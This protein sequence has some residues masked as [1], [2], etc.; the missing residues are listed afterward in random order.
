[1]TINIL[2]LLTNMRI[3]IQNSSVIRNTIQLLPQQQDTTKQTQ[4][5]ANKQI[6]W[7]L[8]ISSIAQTGKDFSMVKSF[9]KL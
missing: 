4:R 7:K 1:M 3:K 5:A 8:N 9:F 6:I 2:Q